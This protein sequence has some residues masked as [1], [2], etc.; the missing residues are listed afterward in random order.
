[1]QKKDI[2]TISYLNIKGQ[3][4]FKV[5]KQF[6]VEDFL[7][8]SKS[9][10]LHLQEVHIED[11]TFEQCNFIKS[12]FS[13]ISNN[14][15]NKYGTAS[16][17]KNG[18]EFQNILFDTNGRIIVFE[19]S[20][21][22]F[23]NIYLPSGTDAESRSFREKL[24]AE[25]IPQMMAK[26]QMSGCLG[27]DFNAIIDKKDVTNNPVSKISPSLTRLVNVFGWKDSFR[28][29]H[30]HSLTFSRYY[31]VRGH[32]G[33]S[34]IDRQYHWGE[35]CPSSAEYSPIAFSDHLA[36]TIRL[37]VPDPFARMCCPKSRPKFQ[38]RE[39][40]ARDK[41]FQEWV[42]ESMQ[43]WDEVR[44]QGLPVLLW[45]EMIVKPGIRKLA[46]VRSKQINQEKRSNLNLLL[47]RQSYLM[48]K[49]KHSNQDLWRPRLTE[50]FTVQLQIQTWYQEQSERIQHQTRVN[51]FQTSEKTRI[52]HHEL[53]KRHISKS[54]I[55]KLQT[56]SGIITGHDSCAEYLENMV[57]NL[58]SKPEITDAEAQ[59]ILLAEVN[60][61]IT[62][63]DNSMLSK[64]PGKEEVLKTL[65]E[66]NLRAAPGTDGI[67]SL[68][69]KLC[70]NSLG[71]A[72]TVVTKAVVE[73][74]KPPSSMRTSLMVFGTKP[75]KAKSIKPGDK[76]RISILNN[77]FK[78]I[79]N[80]IARRFRKLT[81]KCLSPD[82]YVGG[83]DRNIHHGIGKA[84]NAIFA[85]GKMRDGSGIADTD[86]MAAF[87]WM[88]LSWVWRVLGKLGVDNHVIENVKNLYDDSITITVVNNK[89][90]RVFQD[91][92]GS[93][94]QGGCASMD[95]FSF[96]IDPLLRYLSGRLKGILI[97]SVP[98]QG[99]S[100]QGDPVPLPPMEDRFKLMAFCDDVKPAITCMAE[101]TIVDKGC[102]LFERSSGCKLHRD[103][104]SNKCKFLP[105][106]RWRGT[107][108]QEDIP[109]RY[110]KISES[111]DM[112]GVELKASWIQ[113]RK[114]NGD[115]CQS[116]M[117]RI[118]NAWK[119][120]K[121]MNL[122]DRP[123]SL[124]S[125]AM[126]K[127]WFKCH[128]ID[129]RI[130]DIT[131]LTSRAK[132]WLFQDILEK[133]AE[134]VLYRPIE[135]GGLGLH[136]IQ[137][138][139]KASLIR[140]FLETSVNPSYNHNLYHSLL[141]KAFV[142]QDETI[143]VSA[144]PFFSPA[145]FESIR[146][147]KDNTPLNIAT[148]TT[149]QWYRVM[150]EKEITMEEPEGMP[151]QYIKCKAELRSPGTDWELTWS[152]SRQKGLGSDATSFLWK[153]LHCILPTEE[154]LSRILPNSSPSCKFCS[155]QVSANLEHC[156]F[157]CNLTKTV[158]T[159]VLNLCQT[160]CPG[161][162]PSQVL[163]LE[164]HVDQTEETP[165]VW[166][167]TQFLM[168]IWEARVKGKM[169]D[170][171]KVRSDLESKVNLLRE[172]R[173][174]NMSLVITEMLL[175]L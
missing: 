12:N 78:I 88:L 89:Y 94:R 59:N 149:A 50:L 172:T 91:R 81:R 143:S 150:L 64:S 52:Y 120:G 122:T 153:L 15:V 129:L 25:T 17:V 173:Y 109:L 10:I 11:D 38:I 57:D 54:S 34:R 110:M 121:F 66:A 6:Q 114:V 26:R 28:Y 117:V 116:K 53:H 74:E 29:L 70:W 63:A 69:Y 82:Q 126:S 19:I 130:E 33:A 80:L 93:I 113:T 55:L 27:G 164:L 31:E 112:V 51:E 76:R 21:L 73:G 142:M 157:Y 141:F 45:W 146:W 14:A 68:V 90:G 23:G 144:P 136:N 167:V 100:L 145:F 47:L 107:L 174:N 171:F 123:W 124:N 8:Q 86:F 148:M 160:F 22:T 102:Q 42:G 16:L 3:T 49:I 108:Q 169:A 48:K 41:D 158:G 166:V 5:D 13:V 127:L 152:L 96:G 162:T 65:K 105:L 115:I 134:M 67:T 111:L 137:I 24:C 119:S 161:I 84:R 37:Q 35:V 138:K 97:A 1:M 75:K 104:S 151:R 30:P 58:L 9:D 118:I 155:V 39:E 103:P 61:V 131:N 46:M 62:E 140:T 83:S 95:W 168:N 60:P 175:N 72:L 43:E 128:T 170:L 106:G 44:E 133:P 85:A 101:F 139:S 156:F 92:R 18:L 147:V 154:R 2:L 7:K 132:S 163:R 4:G 32:Q 77:D 99:P 71:D 20:G 56:E 79:E 98:L 87:D 135:R 40:V 125:F 159:Q 36:H 165:I